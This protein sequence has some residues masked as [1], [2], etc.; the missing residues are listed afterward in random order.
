S[1]GAVAFTLTVDSE[2]KVTLD[3]RIAIQHSPDAGPDQATG[4]AAADLV[5]LVATLTDKDGDFSSASLN[6]GSAISFKDDAPGILAVSIPADI[7]QVDETNLG[8][9]ATTDFSGA[10]IRNYGADGAGT[11]TY[12]LQV[13]GEGASSGL[14][15][16]ATGTDIKV[17]LE[18]GEV[19]GRVGGPSGAIA[20]TVSVDGTGKVTLDQKLAIQHS[21]D[22]GPDQ[23]AGLSAADLVKLVATI[24]DKDGDSSSATLNL[25]NAISF[26]DDAPGILAVS[27]PADILQVDETNLG[28]D[29]TTDFSGAFIRNYGADGAG[30]TTYALQVSGEGASSGLKDIATGTDIKVYLEGGEVVG[31]VGGPSGAIAFT[32]SVDGTGK[33]TLDQRIAIQHSPDSGPDQEVSLGSADLVKLVATLTDKDGDSSSA[34][35]NLGNAISFKDDAPSISAGQAG[36]A[37][38]E[39]DESSLGTDAT[40]DF[41]GAFTGNYGADGAGSIAYSLAVSAEGASSGLKDSATGT[42]IKL[43]LEG[44]Q[45]VGRVGG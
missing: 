3:Q 26:K 28:G 45:V 15:D 24:T 31:R 13:S 39:V 32:V 35:L 11:T 20:F 23:A 43:Y 12:A 38:L 9:D 10:F 30:T 42:D 6:L 36:V 17:Y 41:S 7:L 18:G 2:G 37:S 14:K 5:K 34:S 33:V 1:G 27:I 8:G 4:L 16:I 44:G 19:V 25:G 22:A 21:P 29:A 40:T